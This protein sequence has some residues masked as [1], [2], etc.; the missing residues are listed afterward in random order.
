MRHE[1]D[2]S[3]TNVLGLSWFV[4]RDPKLWKD[5]DHFRPER[6]LD[7]KGQIDQTVAANVLPFSTGT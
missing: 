2:L 7:G 1:I 6:F 5:F 3:D 4:N